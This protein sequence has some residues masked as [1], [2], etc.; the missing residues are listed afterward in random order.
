MINNRATV[1]G[2]IE[3]KFKLDHV[4]YNENFYYCLVKVKRTSGTSDFIPVIVSERLIDVTKDYTGSYVSIIGMFRSY[5]AHNNG[6]TK[7]ILYVFPLSIELIDEP[8]DINDILLEGVICEPPVHRETPQGRIITDVILAVNRE[9]KRSYYIPC[10]AWGR[11]AYYVSTLNV[12]DKL[13]AAG[14]LQS[15][16]YIKNGIVHTAYEFS[17]NLL[18]SV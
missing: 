7:V 17:I 5:N 6:K 3:T 4:C 9:N 13:R 14:R 12:G 1:S 11:N 10:I 8:E 18:E 2:K 15:R 16:E